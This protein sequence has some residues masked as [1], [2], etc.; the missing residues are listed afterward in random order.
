MMKPP[1]PFVKK[2]SVALHKSKKLCKALGMKELLLGYPIPD[3]PHAVSV[4]LPT[5]DAVIGYE[6]GKPDVVNAM[7]LGYPRFVY[8]PY[9]KRLCARI[10]EEHGKEGEGVL[11]LPDAASA[12]ECVGYIGQGRVVAYAD[13]FAVL[14]SSEFAAK[15]KQYWQHAGFIVSSRQAEDILRG[16]TPVESAPICAHIRAYLSELYGLPDAGMS[17]YPSG[18]AAIYT[19]YRLARARR[20]DA[21]T[22]QLGFPYLDTLK[23]QQRFGQGLYM[24]YNTPDDIEALEAVLRAQ[25]IAAV[26]TEVPS[27]PLLHTVDFARLRDVLQKYAVPLIVDDTVATAFNVDMR[28]YADIVVT[29]LTKFYSGVGNVCAGAMVLNPASRFA[30]DFHNAFVQHAR[31]QLYARDA[32]VLRD[33][34]QGFTRRMPLI[35]ANAFQMAAWL[36]EQPSVE[37]VYHP[38]LIDTPCYDEVRTPQGGYGGLLSFILKNPLDAP[39]VFDALPFCKGPSLGTEFTLACPY[40]LLAHYCELDWAAQ[41]RVPAHLIRVSV[42]VNGLE[43]FLL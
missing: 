34:M 38:S 19:A 20:P 26:F 23:I 16:V 8:H 22:V 39:R 18:M 14:Y 33:N 30:D 4:S 11:A 42:G 21:A 40:T 5:W 36:L 31:P 32:E 2:T 9:Y 1:L 7:Q 17:L 28:A 13:I 24:P 15:A 29:S 3:D 27:N 12:H 41:S 43:K 6:E 25:P 35:N 10:L 37:A